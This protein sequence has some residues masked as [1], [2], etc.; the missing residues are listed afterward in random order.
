MFARRKRYG[1]S[2]G[3]LK[4]YAEGLYI[5][6]LPKED[7]KID[8]TVLA[9]EHKKL[10]NIGKNMSDIKNF[11]SKD[12]CKMDNQLYERVVLAKSATN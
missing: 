8:R 2:I 4:D 7:L 12:G 1:R 5:M 3:D 9:G 6:G 10:P 11:W